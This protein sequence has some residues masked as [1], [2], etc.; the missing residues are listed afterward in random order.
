MVLF[1]VFDGMK[2]CRG[3]WLW[4]ILGKLWG[5]VEDVLFP[6]RCPVCGGIVSPR[7]ALICPGC[8]KKLEPVHGPVCKKCGKEI[9]SDQTEYCR[10][11]VRHMRSFEEGRALLNYNEAARISLAAVK[12]KNKREYLDFYASAMA[13]R[14]RALVTRWRPERL[15]PVPVHPSRF[16][17]RGYNQAEEL[18]RRLGRAWD[19]PVD[20]GLLIRTRRTAPQKE[21]G[22]RERLE[23]LRQAFA[24]APS[25][26]G[27]GMPKAVL[28]VDDIYT[29]GSTA[30]ACTR[31][32]LAAGTQKVYYLAICIGYGK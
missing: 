4:W 27:A 18:A 2:G 28:L 30:E 21:L 19:I 32:L 14:Y 6:R 8:V 3:T 31:A 17:S 26:A 24:A 10:D 25:A 11:C 23:N 12:Y 15:V 29:T 5:S 16:R 1:R 13:Y 20:A 22:P 7:G 9:S